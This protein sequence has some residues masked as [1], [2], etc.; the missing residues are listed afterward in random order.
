MRFFYVLFLLM[1]FPVTAHAAQPRFHL[2][3]YD[4][5]IAVESVEHAAYIINGLSGYNLD[6]FVSLNEHHSEGSFRRRIDSWA[7]RSVQ[8]TL[9]S[10]GE[11]ISENET[12]IYLGNE[13]TDLEAQLAINAQEFQRISLMMEASDS[14]NVLTMLSDRLGQLS[15][16]RDGLLGRRNQILVQTSSP[17]INI[18]IVQIPEILEEEEIIPPTFLERLG[19]GFVNSF[20]GTG[21]FF[22]VVLIAFAYMFFPLIILAVIGVPIVLFVVKRM[23]AKSVLTIKEG[24]AE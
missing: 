18:F 12:V 8:E 13:V 3:N 4:I 21:V 16:T 20:R 24:E 14:L 2:Q 22:G 6:A 19:N 15:R 1:L 9:R 23:K 10:L 17:V 5:T 7:Y 11:V